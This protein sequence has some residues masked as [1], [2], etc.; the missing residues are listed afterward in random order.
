MSSNALIKPPQTGIGLSFGEMQHMAQTLLASGFLPRSIKTVPQALAVMIKG[1]EIGIPPM[2]AFAQL[3]VVDQR[4]GMAA[5]L[6]MARIWER[7]PKA[8]IKLLES[9]PTVCTIEC[10]KPGWQKPQSFTW[11]IEDAKSAG[12][13][14]KDNWKKYPRTM[15]RWRAI[16]DMSRFAFPECLN[17]ISHTPEEIGAIVNEEGEIVD[18]E[19][20][21]ETSM[22]DLSAN[23][24][25]HDQAHLALAKSWWDG[26][27]IT[28]P[29]DR[30]KMA[31]AYK[32]KPLSKLKAA[33]D[34]GL[35]EEAEAVE[36]P[37]VLALRDQAMTKAIQAE[38]LGGEV[39][40]IILM[41]I[42]ELTSCE[43][44]AKLRN[45]IDCLD[46]YLAYQPSEMELV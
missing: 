13:I 33:I 32:G 39:Q 8:Q 4:V 18:A 25:F 19:P 6:M 38:E 9:S 20:V 45:A 27:G 23:A 40:Q 14:G 26:A 21:Q 1:Q 3:H 17:G 10:L 37:K 44:L 29:A 5:E 2:Q 28:E 46:A 42:A 35:I 16:A 31:E 22:V 36:D 7:Y 24:N 34:A 15:L 41:N 11:T 30:R 43:D 12:L